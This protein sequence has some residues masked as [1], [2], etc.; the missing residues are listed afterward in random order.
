M[1]VYNMPDGGMGVL[2]RLEMLKHGSHGSG[3]DLS[4][5]VAQLIEHPIHLYSY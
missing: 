2:K 5:I 1:F 4:Q 3:G